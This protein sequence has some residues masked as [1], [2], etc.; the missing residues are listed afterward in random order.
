MWKG[1]GRGGEIYLDR[2]GHSLR[3]SGEGADWPAD[4][5]DEKG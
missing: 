3:L 5:A 1:V 2:F 4:E